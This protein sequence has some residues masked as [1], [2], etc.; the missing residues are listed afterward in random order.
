M[1][2]S[3][4]KGRAIHQCRSRRIDLR[5]GVGEYEILMMYPPEDLALMWK[6][7]SAEHAAD[8]PEDGWVGEEDWESEEDWNGDGD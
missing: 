3:D 5:E 2:K 4:I 7:V 6:P 8:W 1:K